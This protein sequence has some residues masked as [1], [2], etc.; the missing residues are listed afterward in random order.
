MVLSNVA[1][2]GNSDI[3]LMDSVYRKSY[4]TGYVCRSQNLHAMIIYRFIMK[5]Y[6]V[7]NCDTPGWRA[8][9]K[10][11]LSAFVSF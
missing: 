5:Y 11:S 8:D 9:K 4:L 1:G 6:V 7:K 2:A 10:N 3:N